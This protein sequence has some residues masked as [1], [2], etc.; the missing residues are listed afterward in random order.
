MVPAHME[1]K[2]GGGACIRL[3]IPIEVGTKLRIAW[4]WEKFSGVTK[5]CR[6][7]GGE[8]Y[9]G[10]QRDTPKARPLTDPFLVDF[11]L[12]EEVASSARLIPPAPM[13]AQPPDLRPSENPAPGLKMESRA[14][15]P[16][17]SFAPTVPAI[18]HEPPMQEAVPLRRL[19]PQASSRKKPRRS[20]PRVSPPI[21]CLAELPAVQRP[22]LPMD[23][24]L[25]AE[26]TAQE[27]KPMR[28]KWLDRAPWSSKP[29]VITTPDA[30]QTSNSTTIPEKENPMPP[31]QAK[32]NDPEPGAPSF[33][34]ELVAMEDIYRAAGIMMP[35]KGYSIKKVVEMLNSE[36]IR[37]LSKDMKRVALLMALD[38][39]GVSIAEVLQD[40]KARQQ[41]LDAHEA[42]QK[43]RAEAEWT[44]KVEENAQIEAELERIKAHH[45]A[46]VARNVDAIAR[47]KAVFNEWLAQ[48]QQES[49]SM[50]DA[51]DLCL[52]PPSPTPPNP[53]SPSPTPPSPAPTEANASKALAKAV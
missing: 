37:G 5:Y 30:D 11:P 48:K 28:R 36:H 53:T 7:E 41:A 15:L 50:A 17:V 35:R 18:V 51:A 34:V 42:E 45:M 3:R 1:D 26:E 20:R 10:I 19:V 44:R 32:E 6:R 9:V 8:Y 38:A 52:K 24:L 2:S 13:P 4:R 27:R 21:S 46:R 12:P 22:E 31:A 29:D 23:Q 39:A 25:Q 49:Q 40:A 14:M 33:Q 47:E 43:K 16:D